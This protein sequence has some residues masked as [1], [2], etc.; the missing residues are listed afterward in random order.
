MVWA[1]CSMFVAGSEDVSA[2]NDYDESEDDKIDGPG[3]VWSEP[4]AE[5]V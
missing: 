5:V 1:F 3:E 4:S 2:G